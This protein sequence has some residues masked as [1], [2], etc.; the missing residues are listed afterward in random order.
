M[1]R[2]LNI[3]YE[4]IILF[5]K[6]SYNFIHYHHFISLINYEYNNV[7]LNAIYYG[8]KTE[9]VRPRKNLYQWSKKFNQSDIMHSST[10]NTL[11]VQY[12]VNIYWTCNQSVD[13][14]NEL[15]KSVSVTTNS[16]SYTTTKSRV[17]PSRKQLSG[18][19]TSYKKENVVLKKIGVFFSLSK[20]LYCI[21]DLTMSKYVF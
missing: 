16:L 10:L 18:N 21:V 1:V 17:F 12:K 8:I 15:C 9:V 7:Y 20:I 19:E 6:Q 4:N 2:E 3:T 5:I 11:S 14:N 13:S